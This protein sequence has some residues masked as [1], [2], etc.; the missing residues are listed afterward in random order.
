METVGQGGGHGAV[1][2]KDYGAGLGPLA[3]G[4]GDSGMG[5]GSRGSGM[6]EMFVQGLDPWSSE[7]DG[8][9][10]AKQWTVGS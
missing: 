9:S 1:G 3:W 10:G 2:D 4:D 5:Q 8:D 6:M 7:D